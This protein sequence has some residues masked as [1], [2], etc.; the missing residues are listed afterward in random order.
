MYTADI[1]RYKGN[2]IE[3]AK[4]QF[5]IEAVKLA[6]AHKILRPS[7]DCRF[8]FFHICGAKTINQIVVLIKPQTFAKAQTPRGH[9][10]RQSVSRMLVV[11]I[12]FYER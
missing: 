8:Q 5:T 3:K 1:L 9:P 10:P 4:K 12:V 11:P 6:V 2:V 7:T